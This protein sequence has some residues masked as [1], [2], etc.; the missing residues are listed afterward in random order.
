MLHDSIT[1]H[2]QAKSYSL[3]RIEVLHEIMN[4][5]QGPLSSRAGKRGGSTLAVKFVTGP[6]KT[7]HMVRIYTLSHNRSF[8]IL[9]QSFCNL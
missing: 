2:I 9:Q 5:R 6:V 3:L 1:E 7:G 4:T 8:S